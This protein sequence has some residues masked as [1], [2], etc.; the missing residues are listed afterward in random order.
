M[1]DSKMS[2]EHLNLE[3]ATAKTVER[4]ESQIHPFKQTD[5]LPT[6]LDVTVEKQDD[7]LN[8]YL[9][10]LRLHFTTAAFVYSPKACSF[11]EKSSS[12]CLCLFL[13]NLEIPI[14]TT[15]LVGITNDLGGF[16]K[17][18]WIISAYLL[19]YVGL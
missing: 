6:L 11:T 16:D 14:V 7:D 2:A 17:S 1:A 9:K 12:L 13:T 19:G 10:G 8:Q 18:S 4:N 3:S 15:A 5:E